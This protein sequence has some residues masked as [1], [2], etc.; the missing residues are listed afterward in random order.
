MGKGLGEAF[1]RSAAGTIDL[2]VLRLLDRRG[3]LHGY[4]ITQQ[5]AA[6]SGNVLTAV[7]RLAL[8]PV[9]SEPPRMNA[10]RYAAHTRF[11]LISEEFR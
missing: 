3:P 4:A 7:R 9:R 1:Q 5:I 10:D 6:A 8:P 11:T 2:V